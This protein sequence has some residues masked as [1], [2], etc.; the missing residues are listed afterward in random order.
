MKRDTI[1]LTAAIPGLVAVAAI[2]F[3][4]RV[5][6]TPDRLAGIVTILMLLGIAAVE[7]RFDWKRLLNLTR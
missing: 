4:L 5:S 2:L 7:Y 1:L 3:S 6:I